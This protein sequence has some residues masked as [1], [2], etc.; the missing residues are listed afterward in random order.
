MVTDSKDFELLGDPLQ[1]TGY[2][3]PP[4]SKLTTATRILGVCTAVGKCKKKKKNDLYALK[5]FDMNENNYL[6]KL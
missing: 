4:E 1:M 6:T 3:R 2:S 5:L